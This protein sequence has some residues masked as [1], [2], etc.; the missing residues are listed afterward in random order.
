MSTTRVLLLRLGS[1]VD[2]LVTVGGPVGRRLLLLSVYPPAL[3]GSSP[4]VGH[5][6][7]C[8]SPAHSWGCLAISP[9][10]I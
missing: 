1:P 6:S 8:V 9:V 3:P 7:V 2:P 10:L 5:S 4:S